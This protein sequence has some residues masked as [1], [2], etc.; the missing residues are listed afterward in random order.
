YLIAQALR[1]TI[2]H[3]GRLLADART[4]TT[5][6][7][8]LLALLDTGTLP[9][10]WLT[11][12]LRRSSTLT[13]HHL[14][15][16]DHSIADWDLRV[17][18]DRFRRRL[19]ALVQWLHDRDDATPT[20]P[21]RS[22]DIHPPD[23]DGTACLQLHG[24]APEI[25]SLGR[26]LDSAARAIQ[27]D[28][29]KAIA[30]G[31]DIPFDDGTATTTGKPLPLTRLRY[32][33]LTRSILDTGTT[34]VPRERFRLTLTVPAL[35][36]LGIENAPGLLAAIH[37]SPPH[38]AT[39]PAPG[40]RA[41][42][43]L[44]TTVPALTLLRIGTAP[45]PLDGIHPTPPQMARQLAGSENT[46]HRVLTDPTTGAFLPLPA[47]RYVPTPEMLEYLRLTFPVCA[48]PG[49]TRP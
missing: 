5:H 7:P 32:E 42:F 47:D 27:K 16:L 21:Q 12:I 41:R 23:E 22:V 8:Q 17:D 24:P 43:R 46:W 48:V 10:R 18:E 6:L 39:R 29:R 44:T 14:T 49:C 34:P 9:A 38:P 11:F 1:T 4:A 37:P 31:H 2:H 45:G 3:A 19:N 20:P 15:E 36:L 30:T 33:I 28:Q 26:R 40:P 13:P 35:T 25:L